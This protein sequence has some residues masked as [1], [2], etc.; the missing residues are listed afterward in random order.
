MYIAF[1]QKVFQKVVIVVQNCYKENP[2]EAK[3]I[4]GEVFFPALALMECNNS[5][6][7]HIWAILS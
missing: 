3:N 4:A 5:L 1:D 2:E 7:S 6:S